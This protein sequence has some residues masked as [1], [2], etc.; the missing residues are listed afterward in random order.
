MTER[1]IFPAEWNIVSFEPLADTH[2]SLVWKVERNDYPD[3]VF[4]IKQLEACRNGGIA[5]R[6]LSFMA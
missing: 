4:V 2:S 1:P 3:E 5:W 6:A